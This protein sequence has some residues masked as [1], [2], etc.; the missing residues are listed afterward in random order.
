MTMSHTMTPAECIIRRCQDLELGLSDHLGGILGR[1]AD[2]MSTPEVRALVIELDHLSR[3]E[4]DPVVR[5]RYEGAGRFLAGPV[6]EMRARAASRERIAHL[7]REAR[8]TGRETCECGERHTPG[9]SYYVS[10]ADGGRS[11]LASGPYDTHAE[12]LAKV[13]E[14]RERAVRQDGQA[15]FYSWG[16]VAMPG[17]YR[18]KGQIDD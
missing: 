6:L 13:D 3:G 8:R 9:A 15:H 1:H 11:A 14:V 18:K 7:A 16:T 17:T 4:S 10:A 5:R 12:A 2:K